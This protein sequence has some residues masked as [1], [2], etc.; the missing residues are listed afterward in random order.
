[1]PGPGL[2][3]YCRQEGLELRWLR[4]RR[5]GLSRHPLPP[6]SR[7]PA[8]RLPSVVPLRCRL[9]PPRSLRSVDCLSS[10]CQNL[11][12]AVH[13]LYCW[14]QE[15][16]APRA[17]SRARV[18]HRRK[19]FAAAADRQLHE[20]SDCSRRGRVKDEVREVRLV[21]ADAWHAGD[22]SLVRSVVRD[23]C[24]TESYTALLYN[25]FYIVMRFL[26]IG[27]K[28]RTRHLHYVEMAMPCCP[29]QT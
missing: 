5:P 20:V 24:V 27:K 11:G 28:R 2:P 21:A 1:V 18:R 25:K 6:L 4:R 23:R 10:T 14:F 16:Y 13:R 7:M 19:T 9:A 15:P 3:A 29:A 12:S 26:S 22:S 8:V 17:P